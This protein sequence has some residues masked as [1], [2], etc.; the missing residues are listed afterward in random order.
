MKKIL[1]PVFFSLLFLAS[2]KKEVNT[3]NN[4][5]N[6]LYPLA[7]G[8]KWIYVDSFFN[9]LQEYTGKDTF[10]L[11]AASTITVNN[12]VYTPLIDQYADTIFV[13][14][15]NDSAVFILEPSGESLMFSFP[16]TDRQPFIFNSYNGGLLNSTIYTE[17]STANSYP[18]YKILITHDYAQWFNYKQKEFFF[19]IG[20]GIIKGRSIRKNY[21]GN[22]YYY[23]SYKLLS[24][25]LQ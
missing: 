22:F 19:T 6:Q 15:S 25:S 8:S 12:Q 2:C 17:R 4:Q 1:L 20:V 10:Y 3:G 9:E 11:S 16:F 18:G 13:L 24:Y 5:N 7:K 23:E 14:R 21:L